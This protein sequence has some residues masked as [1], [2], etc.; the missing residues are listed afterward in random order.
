Y[1]TDERWL[2]PHF[3][4]MLYDN[5]QLMSAYADGY[6]LTQEPRYREAVADIYAWLSREMTHSDGGFFSALDSES[7]DQEGKFYVWT[8]EELEDVLGAEDARRFVPVYGFKSEGNF[9]EEATGH[10]TGANIPHLKRSLKQIASDEQLDVEVLQ[11][12][13][14]AMRNKLLQ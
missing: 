10:R 1:S 4:K 2:L 12:E 13:L 11:T 8:M 14:A 7:E 5:A 6:Q 3:E 9:T